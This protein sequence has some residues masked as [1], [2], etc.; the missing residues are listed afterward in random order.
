MNFGFT[1]EQDLLRREVRRFLDE[2][3]PLPEVRRIIETPSGYS[4]PLWK[5]LGALGGIMMA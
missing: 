1:E 5:E 3:C 4:E 2:R